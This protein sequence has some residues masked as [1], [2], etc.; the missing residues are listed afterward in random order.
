MIQHKTTRRRFMGG[1]ATALSIVGSAPSL[2]LF[3]Q[4]RQGRQQGGAGAA[5][6]AEAGAERTALTPEEYENMAKLANNENCWGPSEPVVKAMT[7]AFKY[8]NR[9]G[10]PDG[11][12]TDAIAAHPRR[13]EREHRPRRRIGRNPEGDQRNLHHG[14]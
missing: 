9:Y 13:E 12:I 1:M 8:A 6:A 11:G 14:S 10:Y 7:D 5:G 3:A 4:A 2:D